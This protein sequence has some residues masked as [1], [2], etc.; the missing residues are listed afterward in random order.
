MDNDCIPLKRL[1]LNPCVP[2]LLK[3]F[4]LVLGQRYDIGVDRPAEAQG[5]TE[6]GDERLRE[7]LGNLCL[8]P[9][10]TPNSSVD[11]QGIC[12]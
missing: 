2:L 5:S 9:I 1:L 4:S 8:S 7:T 12:L 6:H 11:G 3:D 10:T